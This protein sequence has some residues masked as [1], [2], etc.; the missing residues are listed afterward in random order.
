VKVILGQIIYD[1]AIQE[2]DAEL[3]KKEGT[4]R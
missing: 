2:N 3:L 4:P 1:Q